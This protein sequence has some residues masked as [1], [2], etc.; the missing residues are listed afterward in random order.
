[1]LGRLLGPREKRDGGRDSATGRL[2]SP[3][4]DGTPS[5]SDVLENEQT[6]GVGY[7]PRK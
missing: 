7:F 6:L 4:D 2:R 5:T 1:M 3:V